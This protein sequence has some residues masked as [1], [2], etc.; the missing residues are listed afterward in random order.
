MAIAIQGSFGFKKIDTHNDTEGRYLI[1]DAEI[2]NIRTLIVNIYAPNEDHVIFF[3]EVTDKIR[4]L[5]CDNIIWGGD[6]NL[7]LD[8]NID[9]RGGLPTTHWKCQESL[10]EWMEANDMVDVWRRKYPHKKTY[11]W[12]SNPR[13]RG[14]KSSPKKVEYIACRLDFFLVPF[15]MLQSVVN[16]K[17]TAGYHSDHS[18]V[19]L[20][21]DMTQ[22]KRGKGFW[23]LNNSLLCDHK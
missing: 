9:K 5:K 4:D 10:L 23:K 11:T 12:F 8:I 21:L 19:W 13:L 14:N 2:N 20:E 16:T 17:I 1:L 22:V 15:N 7:V 6:N 18:L 3:E